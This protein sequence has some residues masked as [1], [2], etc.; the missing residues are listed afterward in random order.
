[1]NKRRTEEGVLIVAPFKG[2]GICSGE[3]KQSLSFPS[4]SQGGDEGQ[5]LQHMHHIL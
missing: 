5:I 2:P 1:M 4:L 3:L